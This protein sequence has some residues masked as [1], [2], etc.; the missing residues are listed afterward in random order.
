MIGPISRRLFL[1]M[2]ARAGLVV[3]ASALTGV[4]AFAAMPITEGLHVGEAWA[5]QR[6]CSYNAWLFYE[7][8][9]LAR[10]M[11]PGYE[12]ADLIIPGA[13][14]GFNWHQ[15]RGVGVPVPSTRAE[16][17]LA[18]VGVPM[19]KRFRRGYEPVLTLDY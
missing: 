11:Y 10:E 1:G 17:V 12:D 5:F 3:P 4:T 15:R 2:A 16:S 7:R 6:L 9:A 14:E 18:L 19:E 13:C 8:Q